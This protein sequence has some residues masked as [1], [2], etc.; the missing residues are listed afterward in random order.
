MCRLG[1][2]MAEARRSWIVGS[3]V[4]MGV[5]LSAAVVGF[6]GHARASDGVSAATVTEGEACDQG[7]W[8]VVIRCGERRS[9][10]SIDD[11]RELLGRAARQAR[12]EGAGEPARIVAFDYECPPEPDPQSESEAP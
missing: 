3:V 9:C 11:A 8:A 1:G 7:V 12:K 6:L 10:L 4:L 2:R 5:G